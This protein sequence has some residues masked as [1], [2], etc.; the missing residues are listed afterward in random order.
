MRGKLMTWTIGMPRM[1]RL[2]EILEQDDWLQKVYLARE[3]YRY[4][5]ERVHHP[6][7]YGWPEGESLSPEERIDAEQVRLE[8]RFRLLGATWQDESE[9]FFAKMRSLL[10]LWTLASEKAAIKFVDAI[11]EDVHTASQWGQLLYGLDFE[12]LNAAVGRTGPRADLTL[13]HV[14]RPLRQRSRSIADDYLS[15]FIDSFNNTIKVVTLTEADIAAFLNFLDQQ[16]LWSWYLEFSQVMTELETPT[17]VS[18]DRRFL[19]LRSLSLL[20]EPILAALVDQ[21]G[22]AGDKDRLQKQGRLKEILGVF[23]VNRGKWREKLWRQ[24]QKHFE[25]TQTTGHSLEDRLN[26]ISKISCPKQLTGVVQMILAFTAV[27][28]FGSHQFSRDESLLLMYEEQLLHPAI[29]CPLFYW[30]IAVNLG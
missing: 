1:L 19:H 10:E 4:A 26:E 27:R 9:T 20:H 12:E 28:N 29:F 3:I 14:L 5:L 16:E 21:Y 11:E 7:A 13:A 24:I 17:D 2:I 8:E 22:T 18:L 30:Y 23:L 25:L 15:D 6:K